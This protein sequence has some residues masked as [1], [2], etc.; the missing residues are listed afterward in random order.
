MNKDRVE[1]AESTP[2]PVPAAPEDPKPWQ[3]PYFE[4]PYNPDPYR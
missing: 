2:W 1:P 4:D 3:D